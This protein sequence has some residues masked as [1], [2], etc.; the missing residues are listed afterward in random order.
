[1][2]TRPGRVSQPGFKVSPG[3]IVACLLCLQFHVTKANGNEKDSTKKEPQMTV[4]KQNALL[5]VNPAAF[6]PREDQTRYGEGPSATLKALVI[7]GWGLASTSTNKKRTYYYA[8]TP[9]SYGLIFLGLTNK[10]QSDKLHKQYLDSRDQGEMDGF[11]DKANAKRQGYI[12]KVSAG[13]A[14]YLVQLGATFLWGKYNNAYRE[15]AQSWKDNIAFSITPSY[16]PGLNTCSVNTGLTIKLGS[17]K[18]PAPLTPNQ[19]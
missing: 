5:L 4:Y 16:N 14:V 15:R 7:P 6:A 19:N 2:K 18:R 3:L 9:L 13:V 12:N 10:A 17:K 8:L 1:M 11:L